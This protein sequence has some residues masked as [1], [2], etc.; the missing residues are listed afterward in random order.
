ML[1]EVEL[2]GAN[3]LALSPQIPAESQV[4]IEKNEVTFRLLSDPGNGV[5]KKFRLVF[6]LPDDL[7]EAYLELGIDLAA[8]NGDGAWELPIPATYVIGQDGI[9]KAMHA[10]GDYVRRMEPTDILS[11]LREMR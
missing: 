5:A 1:D 4:T 3:M 9:V 10:N 2:L 7:K 8:V 11:A 6:S